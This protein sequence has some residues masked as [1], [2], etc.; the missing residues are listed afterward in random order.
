MSTGSFGQGSEELLDQFRRFLEIG[1]HDRGKW[2]RRGERHPMR[3]AEKEP[4]SSAKETTS[5]ARERA[6]AEFSCQDF[7]RTDRGCRQPR[8]RLPACHP[9]IVEAP[10]AFRSAGPMLSSFLVYRN[11]Q[12]KLGRLEPR[13]CTASGGIRARQRQRRRRRLAEI[14]RTKTALVWHRTHSDLARVHFRKARKS[15]NFVDARSVVGMINRPP[16]DGRARSTPA[17]DRES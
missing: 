13:V 8:R 14:D 1:G 5:S 2:G 16:R 11:D 10:P 17:D 6:C 7:R 4:S 9:A 3:I 12:G 15:E